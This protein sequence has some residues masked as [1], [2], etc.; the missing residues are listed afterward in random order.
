MKAHNNSNSNQIHDHESR[1]VRLEV[2]VETIGMTLV[3]IENR[4]DRMDEKIE[5]IRKESWSQFRWLLG[6]ILVAGLAKHL[7]GW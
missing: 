4:L 7:L 2:L 3:R 1:I 5:L 6:I